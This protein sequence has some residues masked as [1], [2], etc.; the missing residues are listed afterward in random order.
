MQSKPTGKSE[1]K[2]VRYNLPIEMFRHMLHVHVSN[3][4]LESY[5]RYITNGT[6][7]EPIRAVHVVMPNNHSVLF[8]PFDIEPGEIS[9]E[10]YHVVH[11]IMT[12]IG[13]GY[14]EEEFVAYLL[15]YIVEKVDALVKKSNK[16][17]DKPVKL[18][19]NGTND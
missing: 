12:T 7:T 13:A 6:R 15:A 9:H 10:C 17:L 14:R 11:H 2:E 16:T 1:F 8:L 5:K 19:Y 18:L 3:D 4:P